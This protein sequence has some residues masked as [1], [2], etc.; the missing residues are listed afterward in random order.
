MC[1]V[2]Q[3][4]MSYLQLNLSYIRQFKMPAGCTDRDLLQ[5]MKTHKDESS[6]VTIIVMKN[7][8]HQKVPEKKGFIRYNHLMIATPY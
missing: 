4:S 1:S 6:N 2:E 3:M 5:Y 8:K 7:A